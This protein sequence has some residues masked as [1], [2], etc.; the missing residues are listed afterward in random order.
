[1]SAI[2]KVV[3][4]TPE[5]HAHRAAHRN[6]SETPAVLG[7]SPWV[8]PYQL[9]LQRT[10][11]VAPGVNPAMMR[12]TQLEPVAREAYEHLTGNVMEPLVLA[13][14]DYSASLDGMTLDGELILEIKCPVKG[15]E[16]ELW[17]G[18]QGGKLPEHYQWQV[19]HQLMV[20]GASLAHV[21]VF[22]GKTGILLELQPRQEDW[23]V[24]RDGWDRFMRFI[25]EG[26]EPP[27]M[28]RDT[29]LRTDSEWA[30]AA[31]AFLAAKESADT[32]IARLDDTKVALARLAK[33]TSE[34]GAG[35]VVARY[36]KAGPIDYKKV[37]ELAAVDLELY[38]GPAREEVRVTD[39]R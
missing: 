33:H 32:A 6:A 19:Q 30:G 38:R 5:W 23:C 3:Q 36:W 9:W 13:D 35:V 10:G 26:T 34:K 18:A 28:D 20:A 7:V 12:G 14:G 37:P 17:R 2:L 21:Y 8:T 1:M 15:Q 16:S 31:E 24:I 4:G 29:V 22:D 25:A 39:R 11:R 27:L